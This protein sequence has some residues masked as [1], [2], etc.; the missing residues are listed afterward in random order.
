MTKQR[1]TYLALIFLPIVDWHVLAMCN[2]FAV[3]ITSDAP[4]MENV[5][6]PLLLLINFIGI[7]YMVLHIILL[8]RYKIV[9]KPDFKPESFTET[10]F[11][12]M[13]KH[14]IVLY[15]FVMAMFTLAPVLYVS[16]QA[17]RGL[18][19]SVDFGNSAVST[20]SSTSL[21][22][23]CGNLIFLHIRSRL[24]DLGKSLGF[25]SHKLRLR[26]RIV[27]PLLNLVIFI[28]VISLVF[29]FTAFRFYN[30]PASMTGKLQGSLARVEQLNAEFYKS[31]GKE[32][33]P[34]ERERFLLERITKD[35]V[36]NEGFYFITTKE[37]KILKS[38]FTGLV[39]KTPLKDG[40][41]KE[42]WQETMHFNDAFE[43][44][45]SGE[46]GYIGLF[47]RKLVY[48]TYY[49]N[50]EG[51]N[52]YILSGVSSVEIWEESN[53]IVYATTILGWVF[54]VAMTFFALRVT[55][56]KF[57]PLLTVS[58]MLRSLSRGEVYHE[59][60]E[61]YE[62]GDEMTIMI[63]N[64]KRVFTALMAIGNSMK[65]AVEDL[66]RISDTVET[67]RSSIAG[68]SQTTASSIVEVSAAIE[69]ITSSIDNISKSFN[70]QFD[71]TK[72][73]HTSIEKFSTSM[74]EVREKTDRADDSAQA[75]Y[76]S[77]M[78]VEKDIKDT[79]GI[80]KTIGESTRNITD[81][82]SVIK[83]ISDQINLL[84]LNASIEAAR[85]GDAGRGFA[86]VADEVGKLA[87]KTSAETKEIETRILESNTLIESGVSNI[88]HISESVQKMNESVKQS[89]E[90]I[91]DISRL[92]QVFAEEAENVFRDVNDLNEI[93]EQNFTATQE[94][95]TAT[96]E[97]SKSVG[98][99]N[100]AIQQTM[101]EV[102]RFEE[103]VKKL[104][105]YAIKIARISSNI[106]TVEEK[107]E[108]I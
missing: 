73:V 2:A 30:M 1:K 89:T 70:I 55:T 105:D 9:F 77:V 3:F 80:I 8:H 92:S 32:S 99:M 71:K 68:D 95:L 40:S 106:K 57:N 79:V 102:A 13:R 24:A 86:V 12:A 104:S 5:M 69:E 37:G 90:I 103:V 27:L 54:L 39:N 48:Y 101:E 25:E 50:I 11:N 82:I 65:N 96:E 78:E 75:A 87:D 85:A 84:A 91:E 83:E 21:G 62:A 100:E 53:W 74:Q 81:T 41:V 29:S 19:D 35:S 28:I 94:Q 49:Y 107:Q 23:V 34:G 18:L 59:F 93:S 108:S 47:F 38:N 36:V 46:Q 42:D 72:N 61:D 51:T 44:L 56:K 63:D 64:L 15:A 22:V 67:G 17:A 6:I 10:H 4:K 14:T 97:V 88:L 33:V 98:H 45:L 60:G 52:L 26:Y 76:K 58:T 20:F 16:M 31:F 7:I 43:R 66:I